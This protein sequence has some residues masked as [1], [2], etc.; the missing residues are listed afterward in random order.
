MKVLDRYQGNY[1]LT[2][3]VEF[4]SK[5]LELSV[6]SVTQDSFQV[7]KLLTTTNDSQS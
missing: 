4:R 7:D 3:T 2:A 6:I 1:F 5:L